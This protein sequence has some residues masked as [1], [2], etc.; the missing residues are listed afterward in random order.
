MAH[1]EKT[2]IFDVAI[3]KVYKVLTNFEAYPDFMDGV[4]SVKVLETNGNTIKAEYSLNIIKKFSYVMNHTVEEPTKISWSFV[5]GDLFKK[6]DGSWTLKDLGDGKTEVTYSVDIDFKV[7][8][9]GMVSKKLVSSNLPS[10]LKAVQ[11]KAK[12][13]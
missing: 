5:S 1:A 8:V 13:L 3:D 11:K 7:M 4:S 12:E 9:P 10:M 6:S 2:E